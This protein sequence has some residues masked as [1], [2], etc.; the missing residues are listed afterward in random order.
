MIV[1]NDG[2]VIKRVAITEKW[3]EATVRTM[4]DHLT[5]YGGK[6]VKRE[7]GFAV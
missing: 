7:G 4:K 1:C 6:L 3:D 5:K 2:L